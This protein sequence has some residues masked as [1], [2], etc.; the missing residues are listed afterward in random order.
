MR[1]FGASKIE[2]RLDPNLDQILSRLATTLLESTDEW[3]SVVKNLPIDASTKNS[4]A[5][6]HKV[7]HS[8]ADFRKFEDRIQEM[9][10]ALMAYAKLEFD[11][12]LPLTGAT[13]YV[14]A[15]AIT[16]N[17]IGEELKSS[18][19]LN[20]EQKAKLNEDS[21]KLKDLNDELISSLTTQKFLT[22]E[23]HHRV[24][25]NL[26]F[27]SSL[28]WF[29]IKDTS[30]EELH[31]AFSSLEK[32]I[33]VIAEVHELM[34][35]SREDN[36]VELKEYITALGSSIIA[37]S[38]IKGELLVLGETVDINSECANYLGICMNELITNT[39]KHGWSKLPPEENRV[40]TIS[41]SVD[42]NDLSIHYQ[43]QGSNFDYKYETRG[44]GS[45]LLEKLLFQ[46]LRAKSTTCEDDLGCQKF[47]IDK[48]IWGPKNKP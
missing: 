32:Q 14:E 47:V 8:K 16:I 43:E 7:I 5:G 13:D 25:N 42:E 34:L 45:E 17:V 33:N 1:S 27:I 31:E 3:Q 20:T 38:P 19:Q 40:L 22:R 6:L 41:I 30:N 24:K 12:E 10:A 39:I 29:H 35:K 11:S 15:L 21:I 48:S 37:A 18:Y 2:L 44:I 28:L 4:L 46:Q 36:A 26:Q 9:Q 23:L